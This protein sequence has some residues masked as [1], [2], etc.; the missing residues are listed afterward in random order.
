MGNKYKDSTKKNN[1]ILHSLF[2][3]KDLTISGKDFIVTL[4]G[5]NYNEVIN[6]PKY[7]K[8]FEKF[9][10]EI[11]HKIFEEH[12]LEDFFLFVQRFFSLFCSKRDTFYLI[13]FLPCSIIGLSA[14]TQRIQFLR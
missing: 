7:I 14:V 4:L 11:N 12:G 2:K 9:Y 13:S 1:R 3:N 8:D 5:E 10:K 6:P